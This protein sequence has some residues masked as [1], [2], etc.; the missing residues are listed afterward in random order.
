M[1]AVEPER[2]S[3][4]GNGKPV[5]NR[6]PATVM[7]RPVVALRT[8]AP[9]PRSFEQRQGQVGGQSSQSSLIGQSPTQQSP[10]QQPGI[11]Q[12]LV[13]Q[14]APRQPVSVPVTHQPLTRDGFR[15]VS[16]SSDGS[17][18]AKPQPRVWEEQGTPEPEPSA[19]PGNRNAQPAGS[20]R[21]AQQGA[22]QPAQ[23]RPNPQVRPVAPVQERNGQQQKEQEQKSSSWQQRPAPPPQKQQSPPA[24]RQGSAPKK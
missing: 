1:V 10:P 19:P 3:V 21:P 22:H 9:M 2:S 14:V 13:R 17:N 7:T 8:P 15:S 12:S 18:Q 23:Q 16:M 24:S 4:L 5:A 6:P 20:S 11:H